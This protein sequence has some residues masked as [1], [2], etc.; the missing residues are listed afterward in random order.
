MSRK[1]IVIEGADFT[2]KTTLARAV[3]KRLE[4][5][6]TPY[7]HVREPG[8]TKAAEQLRTILITDNEIEPLSAM[9]LAMVARHE[10][11]VKNI[12]PALAENKVV[13]CE[14]FMYSTWAYN[15]NPYMESNPEIGDVFAGLVPYVLGTEL[16]EPALI[17]TE[18]SDAELTRRKSSRGALDALESKDDT[19]Q[20]SVRKAYDDFTKAPNAIL[21]NTELPLEEQVQQV[22]NVIADLRVIEEQ[23]VQD[24]VDDAEHLDEST[25]AFGEDDSQQLG[26]A[27]VNVTPSDDN[28]ETLFD[29]E[30]SITEWIDLNI[31]P[32]LFNDDSTV[33]DRYKERARKILRLIYTRMGDDPTMFTDRIKLRDL[34]TQI[35]SLFHYSHAL[36]ALEASIED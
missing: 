24:P 36:E 17:L 13:I 8:G 7:I 4:E 33:V 19:Y 2:G 10:N 32:A 12:L 29:L 20:A 22:M 31:T 5:E 3:A 27:S 34:T 9:T 6:G 23:L 18:C 11:I 25:E 21:L 16:P 28:K 26:D 1:F 30:E 15:V 35:H 14:R